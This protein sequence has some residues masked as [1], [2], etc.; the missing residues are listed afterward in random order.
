M[1]FNQNLLKLLLALAI[2]TALIGFWLYAQHEAKVDVESYKEEQKEHPNSNKI[3]VENYELKEIDDFNHLKWRLM[4]MHGESD[5]ETKDVNL[6]D[7]NVDYFDGK[8]IKM[9]LSAPTGLANEATK[10]VE[11]LASGS[12]R[13]TCEGEEGKSEMRANKVELMK[14][15]QFAATGGV[16][17]VWPGVAKVTGD[18][19]EGS[20]ANTDLNNLKV[21]GNTHASIGGQQSK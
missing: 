9:R 17:I 6:T 12:K 21:I 4:A 20:L 1:I 18:R 8:K 3:R 16:N 13:V 19:A 15:N 5:P 2:P 7:V 14:K 11:L 10:K